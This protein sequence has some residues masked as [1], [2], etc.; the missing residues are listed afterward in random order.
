MAEG[1]G[2]RGSGARSAERGQGRSR[3]GEGG[4]PVSRSEAERE[5]EGEVAEPLLLLS[6][7]IIKKFENICD[8][9][10]IDDRQSDYYFENV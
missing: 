5:G 4:K 10:N 7:I 1:R 6:F 3:G 9:K 2:G 8:I